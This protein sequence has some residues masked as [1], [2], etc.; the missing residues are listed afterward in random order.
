MKTISKED[1]KKMIDNGEDF[2]LINVLPAEYFEKGH[3]PG[4]INVPVGDENFMDNVNM[5]V[6]DKNKKVVVYC[7]NFECQASP[8]AAQM[9]SDA[10][11]TDVYDY[12]GGIK[13][14]DDAGYGLEST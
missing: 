8:K 11:Y 9:L 1:L 6:H 5:I 14:W 12:E 7:A 2:I 13:E 3:I 10:D 4:S